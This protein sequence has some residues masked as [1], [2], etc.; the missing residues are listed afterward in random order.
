MVIEKQNNVC[1]CV[2]I[3]IYIYNIK[4]NAN[5]KYA[6]KNK[7]KTQCYYCRAGIKPKKH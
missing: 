1:V 4:R 5:K 7:K 2:Y 6:L 3:Y